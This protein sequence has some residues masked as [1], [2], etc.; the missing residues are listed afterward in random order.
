MS[1][2]NDIFS[3]KAIKDINYRKKQDKQRATNDLQL[4]MLR[5]NIERHELEIDEY[6]KKQ[7]EH[8]ITY[9]SK[10]WTFQDYNNFSSSYLNE[11]RR[12]LE[13]GEIRKLILL[14]NELFTRKSIVNGTWYAATAI[15]GN[16]SYLHPDIFNIK[17]VCYHLPVFPNEFSPS[18][19]NETRTNLEKLGWNKL[20]FE[21][22]NKILI[23]ILCEVTAL[24]SIG[25]AEKWDMNIYI[26]DRRRVADYYEC[27]STP[28]IRSIK[29]I[30]KKH[31]EFFVYYEEFF[32]STTNKS[33]FDK[34]SE[35]LKNNCPVQIIYDIYKYNNLNGGEFELTIDYKD[36][37]NNIVEYALPIIQEKKNSWS[38]WIEKIHLM[39]MK[40]E[41]PWKG[42]DHMK[43]LE[44][45]TKTYFNFNIFDLQAVS[46]HK[47]ENLNSKIKHRL[48]HENLRKLF[49]EEVFF[50]ELEKAFLIEF[51]DTHKIK[52]EF[53][54]S[55]E[56]L[57]ETLKKEEE[58][59]EQ[60]IQL[61]KNVIQVI[62]LIKTIG[63]S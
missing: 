60:K 62:Q 27:E 23:D 30:T 39:Q 29:E 21:H 54:I 12:L 4:T 55:F 17:K 19:S 11:A 44:T 41:G 36:I 22:V 43:I 14:I 25:E 52:E 42:Y 32:Y 40:Y 33:V 2:I 1:W 35:Y 61:V 18:L 38:E 24:C 13:D 34:A 58:E 50:I 20:D 59:K 45:L 5:N 15:T 3:I 48:E 63:A 8:E 53:I 9:R 49:P 6:R 28:R 56:E 37:I 7:L 16:Q 10:E 31:V 51:T 46:L 26:N 57:I 47:D